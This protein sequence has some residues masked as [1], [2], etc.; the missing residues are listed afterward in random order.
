[1]YSCRQPTGCRS[2]VGI[3][4]QIPDRTIIAPESSGLADISAMQQQPVVRVAHE[5]FRNDG[6]QPFFDFQYSLAGSQIRAIRDT[7]NMGI[8]CHGILA[9]GGV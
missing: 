7:E 1:M 3:F 4:A 9:E 2:F 6:G 8:D 5:T